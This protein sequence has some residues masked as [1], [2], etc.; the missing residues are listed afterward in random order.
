MNFQTSTNEGCCLK[1]VEKIFKSKTTE[2]TTSAEEDKKVERMKG[3]QQ[4]SERESLQ[5][6]YSVNCCF[7]GQERR[8]KS[9]LNLEG[10]NTVRIVHRSVDE[11]DG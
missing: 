2:K 7:Q 3:R 5:T 8:M 11:D 9:K 4:A 1:I 10:S 6:T